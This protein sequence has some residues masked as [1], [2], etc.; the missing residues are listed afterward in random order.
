MV[1]FSYRKSN[2]ETRLILNKKIENALKIISESGEEVIFTSYD[3]S[4]SDGSYVYTTTGKFINELYDQDGKQVK[5]TFIG[6]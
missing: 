6:L 2:N 3:E 5:F 1:E 4:I